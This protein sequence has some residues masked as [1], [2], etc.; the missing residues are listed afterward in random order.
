V[1]D[2]VRNGNVGKQNRSADIP[3]KRTGKWNL[4]VVIRDN[5]AAMVYNEAAT[6][7]KGAAKAYNDAAI[8]CKGAAIACKGV[9]TAYKG[10]ATA[11]SG[12][13][14]VYEDEQ[15]WIEVLK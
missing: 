7:Y 5:G 9:A 13:E 1:N 15:K 4:S 14:K 3:H 6:V 11:L 10:A 2:C 8:A 12:V